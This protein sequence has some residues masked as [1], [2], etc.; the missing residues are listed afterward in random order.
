MSRTPGPHPLH[1]VSGRP[2][3]VQPLDDGPRRAGRC[4]KAVPVVGRIAR[5][6][7]L[8]HRRHLGQQARSLRGG[9]G[10][11]L[12]LA[13]AHVRQRGQ[14]RLEAH[15][16]QRTLAPLPERFVAAARGAE[17]VE[18][19]LPGAVELGEDEDVARRGR[20]EVACRRF[21]GCSGFVHAAEAARAAESNWGC[22]SELTA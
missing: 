17:E 1:R 2:I 16:Q 5:Q 15:R 9:D 8:G 7:R 14:Q 4:Q 19:R 10:N 13:A 3:A 21:V 20:G 22:R 18:R 6:A 12:E 11:G